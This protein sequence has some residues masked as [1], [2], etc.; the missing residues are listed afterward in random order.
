MKLFKIILLNLSLFLMASEGF[1]AKSLLLVYDKNEGGKNNLPKNFRDLTDL[2]LNAIAGAQFS[3]K[4]LEEIKNKFPNEKILIVDL[5]RESHGFI[6]GEAVSWRTEFDLSNIDKTSAEILKDE[7]S[8]FNIIKK[9]GEV[10]VNRIV[11][12]DKKNGWYSAVKPEFVVI[13]N[14]TTEEELAKKNGF[15]YKRFIIQ[16]HAKPTEE[17]LENIVNFIKKLPADQKIYVHCA[18]GKGRTTTFLTIYDIIKNGKNISLEKILERQYK[19]GGSRLGKIDEEE[20]W[21]E[22]QAK[23]KLEMI[24]EFYQKHS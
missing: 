24:K 22:K 21:R 23:E 9:D 5:R 11:E 14:V 18:A 17:Q 3:E 4:N 20:E 19:A 7:K 13:N 2:G 15:E 8:H 12:K 16:D 10:L 1:A 6:N